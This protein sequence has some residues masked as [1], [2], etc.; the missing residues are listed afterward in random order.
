[1]ENRYHR[2]NRAHSAPPLGTNGSPHHQR[3]PVV[4]T[5]QA[6]PVTSAMSPTA[7]FPP[8]VDSNNLLQMISGLVSVTLMQTQT[9]T[10]LQTQLSEILRKLA[11][12]EEQQKWAELD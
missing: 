10:L 3:D 1:M 2:P 11:L 4:P 12:V 6:E 9:Q 8:L 7:D 5:E